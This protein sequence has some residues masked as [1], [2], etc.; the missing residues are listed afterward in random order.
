MEEFT[1]T[2]KELKEMY[3]IVCGI[4]SKPESFA[5]R[6][7]VDWKGLGL[8][9]YPEV[10][11]KPMDLGTVKSKMESNQYT[12]VE[13]VATD[14]RLVWS[15]CM[16]Y[17]RDGSEFYHLADKFSRGF[18][19]A[20]RALRKLSD[21]S[22]PDPNRIPSVDEKIQLS[23]DIFKIGNSELARV[24]TI[25]ETSAPYA[26][27]RKASTDEVLINFDALPAK[28]FHEVD[29]FVSGC[30]LAIAGNNKRGKKRKT[31]G[32]DS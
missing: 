3:K 24:L 31:D 22:P 1:G 26:L 20:Y 7:P 6:E 12:T 4:M 21:N 16:L 9:D 30:V 28:V 29:Q 14:V 18:E 11:K 32:K 2:D 23:H 5:F 10:V 15:N 13:E 8:L 17:N 19:G 25:I 27:S